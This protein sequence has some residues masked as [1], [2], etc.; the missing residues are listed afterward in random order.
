MANNNG[1]DVENKYKDATEKFLNFMKESRLK[2]QQKA[3]EE[4]PLKQEAT[5]NVTNFVYNLS[6][7]VLFAFNRVNYWVDVMLAS[8]KRIKILSLFM[9]LTLCYFV[10]GGSG[11]T[12]TKSIDYINEVPVEIICDN[13]YH[14]IGYDETVT[15]Q[16]IGDFGSIQWAK[17]M[18]D[19]KVVLKVENKGEGNYD[20]AYEV[21]GISSNLDVQVLPE[22]ATINV[23]KKETRSFAL[24]TQFINEDDMDKAN[25]L[26]EVRLAFKEVEVTAGKTTLD[27]IERVVANI[28]VSN[29]TQSVVDQTAFIT[30]LDSYGNVLDV[31]LSDKEV[32]YD[33]DVISYSK[34]VPIVLETQG[35]VNSDYILTELEPSISQVTIYGLE[36]DLKD[37]TS[38]KALVNVDGKMSND[39]L[40]SVTL[41]MPSSVTKMST[42]TISVN[43]SVEEKTT[44][45]IENIIIELE[46]L[47]N[48]LKARL[49][50]GNSVQV[51]VTG[52]KSK[53]DRLNATSLKVYIDLS[54]ASVGTAKYELV[55]ANQDK[56]IQY[57]IIDGTSVDVAITTGN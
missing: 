39:T 2:D 19:Y 26:K 22:K 43:I 38:V 16:L 12:T 10:N 9:A 54:H 4:D 49:I 5:T 40:N 34:T 37:I 55:I 45:T 30:A 47:P 51:K 28:D 52:P 50:A 14:V 46:S 13:T 35:E 33:L 6:S 11:I 48:G 56:N 29:I 1:H 18:E 41:E 44:K 32:T 53:I 57:E 24:D 25:I 15:I 8:S 27:R 21:E 3:K 7:K 31:N 17:V 42:K 36:E 20:I 23:S